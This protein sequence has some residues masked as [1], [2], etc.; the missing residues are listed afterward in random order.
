[1]SATLNE[2]Y[3]Q[4]GDIIQL[5]APSNPQLNE[6]IFVID[7]IN[8]KKINIKQ[9]DNT[10]TITLNINTDGTLADESIDNIDI[11]NRSES[12]GYAKQNGLLPNTWIDIHFTGDIPITGQITNLEEDMI[13][14]E[15][16][17]EKDEKELIY[18]DF[19][20]KGIPENIPI[21]SIVI[22]S[23]PIFIQ[24]E[25][26]DA[27]IEEMREKKTQMNID[28][29]LAD[30][31]QDD[32][33]YDDA[34]DVIYD[35]I[36]DPTYLKS[37]TS[38]LVDIPVET[39]RAQIKDIILEADQIE[40]G[41][42]LAAI[43]TEEEVP[44]E[45]KR[46]GIEIQTNELLDD[47]LSSIPNE[48][49]TRNVLNKI[50]IMIERFKQL[51]N[52]YSTFDDN[53]NVNKPL[54][55]GSDYK[56]LVDK[57]N[58]LNYK[59]N[60]ILP[61]AQNVKKL[62][63]LDV[64][65]ER[66]NE[67]NDVVPLTL[68]ET[69]NTQYDIREMYK[70]NSDSYSIY[71]NKLQPSLTPFE[72]DYEARAL[73]TQS[74]M[75][76]FDTVI[77]NLDD[78]YSSIAKNDEM[79]RKRFI[80]NRYNLGLSKLEI[81]ESTSIIMKTK[82]VPMTNNDTITVNSILTFKEPIVRF[83]NI[84]LPGTSII[85]KSN[86]NTH[87]LKYWKVFRE[88]TS[89]SRK[90]INNLDEPIQF[91]EDS[92]LKQKTQY[93]L[94][95]DNNDP[96]KFKKFLNVIIPKTRVLFNL[97]KKYINGKLS[98]VSVVKYLQPFLVYLDD[99]SFMQYQEIK[100]YIEKE[101]LSY[102]SKFIQNQ[103]LFNKIKST[104]SF[105]YTSILYKILEGR[106]GSASII[107]EA[108]G[109]NIE[110]KRITGS[111]SEV[112]VLSSSE[113]I[114]YMNIADYSECFNIMQTYLNND[115]FTPF[116]FD[117]LL[118]EK[119]EEYKKELDKGKENNTCEQYIL[120][121]RYISL[122]DINAD[123]GMSIYFDKKYDPTVYDI[124][125][126]YKYERSEMDE[127]VFKNFL[128]DQLIQNI[129]LK[130]IEAVYEATSMLENK[131]LI[132]DGQYAV[133]EID[134]IDKVEY[135]YY[136][137][138]GNKWIRDES[139]PEN[140]FFGSNQLFCN[141]QQK[142]IQIDKKC[143][144]T[145]YGS[146]LVKKELIKEMFDEFD[147]TY[148]ENMEITK[149]KMGQ[150]LNS[151]I[152]RLEKIRTINT[153]LLYKYESD[154]IKQIKNLENEQIISPF[155]GILNVIMG[156]SDF[157][158]K[159]RDIVKFVK[160]YTRP[161][162]PSMDLH[163]NCNVDTCINACNYWLYCNESNT[164]LLP[165]FIYTLASVF[166]E[167][168]NYFQTI[169]EIKNHQGVEVDDCIVDEHSGI[170]IEK[171]ALSTDEGYEES[172][173]K[174]QSRDKLE[175]TAGDALFQ[176]PNEQKTTKKELLANPKGKI[177]NNV[178]SSIS[179]Y[180]GIVLDTYRDNIIQDTLLAL[181]E[182]VDSEDVYEEK[183]KKRMKEG[184]KIPSYIDVFNKS[185]MSFTLSYISLYISI[186]IPS[187]QSNKTYP[188]CKRS[189][190]GYP[191]KGDEDLSN[192]QYIAC[193]AAGIKTN[194]YP[195]KAIPKSVDKITTVIKNTLDAYI[196]KQGKMKALINQKQN[197]LL[198]NDDEFIPIELDI[199]NWINFLPPLQDIN[200]K[201]PV[202]I[203]SSFGNSLKENIS[204]GSK[205]QFEKIS[206][207]QSKIIYFSMNIIQLIQKVVSKENPIL[208]NS[209]NIPFLQNACCNSGEYKTIDYFI[210]REPSILKNN[211]IVSYLYNINFDMVNMTQPAFL[212]DP[213]NTKIK[214]P[215]I[216]NEFSE[217]TIIQGVIDFC[218]YNTYIPVNNRL[219]DYCL[220]KPETYDKNKSIKENIAI[221]KQNN[222]SYS[223][224]AFNQLLDA[225]NKLNIIP[226]DLIHSIPSCL[227]Q[228][229]NLIDYMI[230]S[231]NSM[232][233]DF[234][235]LYKNVLDTYNIE[236]V[237]G[238]NDIRELRNYLGAN[239]ELLQDSVFNYLNKYS[240]VSQRDKNN[241]FEFIENI[242]NFS[243]NGNNYFTNSEDE[244][245]YRAI[246]FIK[247]CMNDF[248]TIFPNIIMNNVKYDKV[249][250]PTHW[251]L[252][253]AH[254]KDVTEII[255]SYYTSFKK[256]YKDITIQP[257][258][259]KN[260][261]DLL[262]FFKLVEYTN[263]YA[264]IIHLNGTETISILDNRTTYQ[265]FQ[266]F[267]LF[268]INHLFEL[269]NDKSLLR[270]MIIAPE[271]EDIIV[272]TEINESEDLGE[273]TELDV[274]RG[275][276]LSIREKIANLSTIMLTLFK[277][278]KSTINYNVDDIKEKINRKKDQER[279]KI[280]ST[281]GDMT[282]EQRE[283]ENLF[284]NHRLERWN[285]GLQKG[286][287]QYVAKTYDE[288]RLEREKEQIMERH[289][290]ESGLLQQAIIADR[291]IMTLEHLETEIVDQRIDD[292]VNDMSNIYDDDDRGD[293]NE[294]DDDYRLEFEE[295]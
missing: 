139:I 242:M 15:I 159:Q 269:T 142:C 289:W 121:K 130:R 244:T 272:T 162:N 221:M 25:K 124:L 114:K 112:N 182:T 17:N 11:L 204:T 74:V 240:D 35:D 49:R 198:Q 48:Q 24:K 286:L 64:S 283:I 38:I 152:S 137:R 34:I 202:N 76:N 229:R 190:I 75:E 79:K 279:H 80:I 85:D 151:K 117:D 218:H 146:D 181:D 4:L 50:H 43:T 135:Y 108:Y 185:L 224:E 245:L 157:V 61:V 247:N 209:N 167:D 223:V 86:L 166:I 8:E 163:K 282:R 215:L 217:S 77:D 93:L 138:E 16:V 261:N 207:I 53:G 94:S 195:W 251:K 144:D 71:M 158:K 263:L 65:L 143:A 82:S 44:E 119:N 259:K 232:G 67:S 153:F 40:F 183:A 12:R 122:E 87:F 255:K 186:S 203:D 84:H 63:D 136:K 246:G 41:P 28:D 226:M 31:R 145:D 1:M 131:R 208:T 288:E 266:Y 295:D 148:T 260:E 109:L 291:D 205:D 248:I 19:G 120:S 103:E 172:G 98:L 216:S 274:V 287:T 83:S 39:I 262:D 70:S 10:D 102:K 199:K 140:S 225:V 275:Q 89:V 5:F 281:L 257:Y 238:N 211:D 78:F 100:D 118:K 197:Y 106:Q 27:K 3:L 113:I 110:G 241:L 149:K 285:K 191:I 66:L 101:I 214:F 45:Q 174:I 213:Q 132:K 179:N 196:L 168:G 276:Q 194:V 90:Y 284:K 290:E 20:Y 47:L 252:S 237:E 36:D 170:E 133:L 222:I 188:G 187:I 29:G 256:F 33:V 164:K 176:I 22:R 227:S 253:S 270:E 126:E 125:D 147:S 26:E 273:I 2:I 243:M 97:I 239:I 37:P 18:I 169:T 177:I 219:L 51:R 171:I 160:K 206:V 99:I 267:F 180:M 233:L 235:K 294:N 178:I 128:I 212:I 293:D 107:L 154:K 231:Q 116:N 228:I 201:T 277:K 60:W 230:E 236:V 220:T 134:N 141:I 123:D 46:Y 156:Q 95:E 161:M 23:M 91:D 69:L 175:Q 210:K 115:L 6:Q 250:I 258:L 72:N 13:E 105:I 278:N 189:L 56:P 68:A 150:I 92:Y 73:T 184:K 21:E 7:F 9:P 32:G 155:A 88:N 165:T 264:S 58:N 96:E 54:F 268:M 59:L 280:T 265:I 200:N 62:Y 81:T 129:G 292:D 14:I 30:D 111:L 57:I 234:L 193:V 127:P 271:K 52:K 104:P 173:F 42:E 55:K 249:K 254:N 192:I